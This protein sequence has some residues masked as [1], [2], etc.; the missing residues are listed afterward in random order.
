[1]AVPKTSLKI[2]EVARRSGLSIRTLRHYDELGLLVPGGRTSGDHR[3]YT[4][5]DMDRLLAIQHLKAL[6]LSLAEVRAALDDPGFDASAALAAHI[7]AVESHITAERE[8]L[9]RLRAL[10]DAAGTGW[11]EVLSVIALT[12]LLAHGEP[13][14]R[15]RA[16]LDAPGTAPLPLLV[17]NLAAESDPGVEGMLTWAVVRRGGH[18]VPFVIA[19][20]ADDDHEVRLRMALV[21]AKIADPRAVAPLIP[22]LEDADPR[23]ASTAAYALGRIGGPEALGALL[24]RLG[25]GPCH[26]SVG[27]ALAR[28]GETAIDPLTQILRTGSADVRARA[29]AALGDIGCA[30]AAP[31][32]AEALDDVD[33]DVR[34]AATIALAHLHR[35]EADA[36]LAR[37]RDGDD[38]RVRAVAERLMTDRLPPRAART[39]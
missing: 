7:A 33:A 3:L 27:D 28:L 15:L 35:D 18:A 37:A 1:V 38:P 10:G 21:L 8:L 2:G 4:P 17:D 25:S 14:V 16:A 9:K 13:G 22:L 34:V 12:E 39:P 36:A 19:R 29:A 23:V 5:D 30:K 11:E 26:D 31:W 24:R 32:L 20:L 6:G